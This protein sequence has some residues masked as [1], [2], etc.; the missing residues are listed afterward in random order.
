MDRILKSGTHIARITAVQMPDATFEA[1]VYVRLAREP[2]IAETYIPAGIFPTSD[3]AMQ[4]AEERAR[5]A[6]DENEF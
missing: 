1:Q 5:R 2:E 3:A 4:G 6:L